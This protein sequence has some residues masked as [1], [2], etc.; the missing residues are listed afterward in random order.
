MVFRAFPSWSSLRVLVLTN[1]AFP[2][3]ANAEG[4]GTPGKLTVTDYA[5]LM[6]SL[7]AIQN[8]YLGQVTFLDPAIIANVISHKTCPPRLSKIQLVD[9]YRG[10][11]WGS[12]VRLGDIEEYTRRLDGSV[13][14]V[15]STRRIVHCG[16]KTERIEGG[17]RMDQCA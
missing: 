8:I 16:A 11:I 12:R 15:E 4:E 13:E 6:S 10:G 3:H 5:T 7:P 9:A 17:D 14:W 2:P 1:L